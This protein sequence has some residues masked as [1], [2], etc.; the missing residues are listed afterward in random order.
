MNDVAE[1]F[2]AVEQRIES[3]CRRA[4]RTRDDVRLV[5]ISKRQ[6]PDRLRAAIELGHR[7][8]GENHA[9][10]L[11]RRR[12]DNPE[13]RW[14]MVGHLQ[15][16]KVKLVLDCALIHTLDSVRL[17]RS[18]NA[19]AQARGIRVPVL[20]QVNQAE[21]ATKSGLPVAELAPVF[22]ELRELPQLE[23]RGLMNIP[24]PGE[25]RRYFSELRELRDRLRSD[26]GLELPELSMGMSGDFEDAIAEGATIVRVGTA[27]FGPRPA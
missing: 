6:P 18:I 5:A 24:P 13:L 9:Q 20:V 10:E 25:G 3:A 11:D 26:H 12:A 4:G 23:I 1:R 15:R 14:H 27:L 16:N 8:Y 7:D 22:A 17:A 2:S 21:E 19:Q